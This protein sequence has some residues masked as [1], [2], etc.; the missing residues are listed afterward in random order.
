MTKVTTP[1]GEGIKGSKVAVANEG[2]M[3][4]S[5]WGAIPPQRHP[6]LQWGH[7]CWG[8]GKGRAWRVLL[9]F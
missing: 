9:P 4:A 3:I 2:A 7:C 5:G 1:I 6:L 8:I